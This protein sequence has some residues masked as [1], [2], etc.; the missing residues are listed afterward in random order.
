[1]NPRTCRQPAAR[2]LTAV[3]LLLACAVA[4][5]AH[6]ATGCRTYEQW[7]GGGKVTIVDFRGKD[8]ASPFR[9]RLEVHG[10]EAVASDGYMGPITRGELTFSYPRQARPEVPYSKDAPYPAPYT[11]GPAFGEKV[12]YQAREIACNVF[13][14]HWKEPNKGDTVTHVQD[15]GRGHVCTNITN[16]NRE[17]IPAGFDPL[18]LH[19]QL[20]DRTLFPDGSPLEKPSFGWYNLCG[21]LAQSLKRD[22]VWEDRLGFQVYRAP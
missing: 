1:M 13:E 7:M 5:T 17:P 6:A 10:F 14:V 21:T 16:I 11:H 15:F 18:D 9:F 19:R 20:N 8:P 22:R 4:G 3:A 12:R 2:A